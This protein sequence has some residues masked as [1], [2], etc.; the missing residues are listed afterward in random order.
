MRLEHVYNSSKATGLSNAYNNFR[1][2]NTP[3]KRMSVT[4]APPDQKHLDHLQTRNKIL[5]VLQQYLRLLK[6]GEMPSPF[7]RA[8]EY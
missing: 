4:K 5:Q 6:R 8:K 2:I 3:R 1:L 7:V